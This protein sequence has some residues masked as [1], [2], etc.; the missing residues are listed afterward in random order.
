VR[1]IIALVIAVLLVGGAVAYYATQI[2]GDSPANFRTV[3]V[4]QGD[5]PDTIEATGTVEP[6]EVVDVGA[7]VAGRIESFGP[8]Y[9]RPKRR[10][11]DKATAGKQ[12]GSKADEP[13]T[14]NPGT[15]DAGKVNV[16]GDGQSVT[17]AKK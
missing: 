17:Q 2:A 7:Q 1:T 16:P 11:D 15:P 5:L 13:E 8:D 9:R 6:E 10:T 14:S 3:Q 12:A 4:T